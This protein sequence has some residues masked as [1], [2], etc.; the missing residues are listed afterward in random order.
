LPWTIHYCYHTTDIN[1]PYSSWYVSSVG[2]SKSNPSRLKAESNLS[3]V[4]L[5]VVVVEVLVVLGETAAEAL[6]ND[7]NPS[8]DESFGAWLPMV[9]LA[10]C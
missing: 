6:S 5:A 8:G 7:T 9:S 4:V 1:I 3:L 2:N 10:L